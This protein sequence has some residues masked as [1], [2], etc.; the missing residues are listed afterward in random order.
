MWV[1]PKNEGLFI[2]F[3]NNNVFVGQK[4]NGGGIFEEV[5]LSITH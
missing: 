3:N 5:K 1:F 4:A 2:D